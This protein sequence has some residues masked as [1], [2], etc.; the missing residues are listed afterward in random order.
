MVSGSIAGKVMTVIDAKTEEP[1]WSQDFDLGVRP[2]AFSANPDGST[3]WA[4]VQLSELNGFAVIDFATRKEIHR[5]KLPR[6]GPGEEGCA[7]GRGTS[8]A[9]LGRD[10]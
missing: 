8:A 10:T 4:F 6:A 1:V 3:K 5:I 9:W 7:R 2:M